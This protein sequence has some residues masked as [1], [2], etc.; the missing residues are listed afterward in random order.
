MRKGNSN[1]WFLF[2]LRITLL[3]KLEFSK[4]GYSYEERTRDIWQDYEDEH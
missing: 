3:V 2:H 4:V 1:G